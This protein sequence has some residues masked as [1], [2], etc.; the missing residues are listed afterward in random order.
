MVRKFLHLLYLKNGLSIYNRYKNLKLDNRPLKPNVLTSYEFLEYLNSQ[1]PDDA[2]I[3]PDEGGHLVWSMQSLKPKNNQRY[4]QILE[5]LQWDMVYQQ[6]LALLL[7]II[8]QLYALM[9]MVGFR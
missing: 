4:F 3:I 9:V 7:E 2:I 6:L 5:I 8:N 1:L